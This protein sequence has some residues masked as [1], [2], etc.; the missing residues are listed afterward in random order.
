MS[1]ESGGKEIS[2]TKAEQCA[3][4][5]DAL[6][7]MMRSKLTCRQIMTRKARV[8]LPCAVSSVHGLQIATAG[9]SMSYMSSK[10]G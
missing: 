2:A 9:H 4:H 8:P 1:R 3:S 10:H 6:F 7:A 5:V